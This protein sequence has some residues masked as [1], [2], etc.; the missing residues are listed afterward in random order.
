MALADELLTLLNAVDADFSPALSSRLALAEYAAKLAANA[1]IFWVSDSGQPL[2]FAGFY[3]ND[4]SRE[5]AYLSM[6]AVAPDQRQTGLGSQL[7]N[8]GIAYLR[9]RG[10]QRLR[11]EVYSSNTPAIA[12]YRGLGFQLTRTSESAMFME[13]DL[14]GLPPA[15]RHDVADCGA[16]F[17]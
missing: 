1:T 16:G 2:A 8:S 5:L 4:P 9:R 3:A 15:A 17:V 10:F 12:L 13:L 14:L 11:L 6:M 7:L